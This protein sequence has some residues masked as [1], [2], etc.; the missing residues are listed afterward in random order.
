[1]SYSSGSVQ[2]LKCFHLFVSH[3]CVCCVCRGSHACHS[4]HAGDELQASLLPRGVW[5]S[6]SSAVVRL[7]QQE[8]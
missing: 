5:G 3:L 7:G 8:S 4:E 6:H 1:M 2:P